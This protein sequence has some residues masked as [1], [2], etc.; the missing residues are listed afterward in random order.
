MVEAGARAEAVASAGAPL[1]GSAAAADA[2]ACV[3]AAVESLSEI[4]DEVG[5]ALD[6]DRQSNERLRY[7]EG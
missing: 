7:L 4:L 1:R 3:L 2:A 5:R 6:A